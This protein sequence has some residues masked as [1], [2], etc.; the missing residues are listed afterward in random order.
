ME[1]EDKTQAHNQPVTIELFVSYISEEDYYNRMILENIQREQ[2]EN[3][4]QVFNEM[5]LRDDVV[6]P[7]IEDELSEEEQPQVG[8]S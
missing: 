4:D 7:T 1:R 5:L 3:F 2:V 6:R 8:E